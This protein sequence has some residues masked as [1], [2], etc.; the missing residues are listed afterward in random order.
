MHLLSFQDRQAGYV[1]DFFR[2]FRVFRGQFDWTKTLSTKITKGTKELDDNMRLL[3][4]KDRQANYA[5]DFFR[6]FRVFR[7]QII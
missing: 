5:I 2:A 3:S 4:F 1:K 7:G 6:A